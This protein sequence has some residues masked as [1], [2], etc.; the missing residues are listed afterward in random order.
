[1]IAEKVESFRWVGYGST[2]GFVL[3]LDDGTR[4]PGLVVLDMN[5]FERS[6]DTEVARLEMSHGICDRVTKETT[7]GPWFS[8]IDRAEIKTA[9]LNTESQA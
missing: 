5:D 6:L 9:I 8:P 2:A 7:F 1:M 3:S 4:L